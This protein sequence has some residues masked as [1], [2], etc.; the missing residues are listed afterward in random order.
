MAQWGVKNGTL[1]NLT[2][3]DRQPIR[4]PMIDK[5]INYKPTHSYISYYLQ[6]R[7][8]TTTKYTISSRTRKS[9]ASYARGF[10]KEKKKTE[11]EGKTYKNLKMGFSFRYP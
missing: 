10:Q 3:G 5:T 4:Q 11:K 7:Q 6:Y 8:I 9:R 1:P 2:P